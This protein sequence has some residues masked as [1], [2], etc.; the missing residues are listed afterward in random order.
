MS[1][2]PPLRVLILS[3]YFAPEPI[4]KP[5]ELAAALHERGHQVSV[6]TGLPHYPFG[7][8][9]P[10][11]RLCLWR[12]ER[13]GGVAVVRAFELPYHG[14]SVAMRLANYGSFALSAAPAALLLPPCDV[15]YV[16]HPPLSLGVPAW[17]IGA[18]KRA[19]FIYDVQD[20]WP[21]SAVLVGAL[22]Q[23]RLLRLFERL[24]RFVYRRAAHLLVVT[25]EAR[26][27]LL[28]KGAP[29]RRVSVMPHWIS[30]EFVAATDDGAS[31]AVRRR[32]GWDGRFV[33]M[34]AGNLG[35]AQA[36]DTLIDAAG[37]LAGD[38]RFL[39]ALV[40]DGADRARLEALVRARGLARDVV[41]L[42]TRPL[43]EMPA[44]MRAADALVVHLSKSPLALLAIPTKIPAYLA[45]GRPL[46]AAV[47]GA[48]AALV[49]ASGAGEVVPPGEP[50]AIAAATRRLAGLDPGAREE[51]GRRGRAFA[52]ERFSKRAVLPRYEDLLVRVARRPRGA[53]PATEVP[54]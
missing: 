35:L 15:I 54:G 13:H 25:P 51:I 47:D 14:P 36:L 40:G 45:A 50:G 38:G 19:P 46:I 18:L 24:E 30:D 7:R 52:L 2:S 49:A 53:A 42:G 12:R 4:P 44:T 21:K 9:Y 37:A 27:D 10:G 8:L 20:I 3:Q 11:Y 16:R 32:N 39:L 34:F 33:T 29:A 41:F 22:R 43:A 23:G 1:A 48:A 26:D 5:A 31:R 6:L 17:L 28:G